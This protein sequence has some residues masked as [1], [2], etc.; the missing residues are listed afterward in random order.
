MQ[1]SSVVGSV[2]VRVTP[3]LVLPTRDRRQDRL[4]FVYAVLVEPHRAARSSAPSSRD[5]HEVSLLLEDE[6]A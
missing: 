6:C 2:S 5:R 4:R 1:K 3:P